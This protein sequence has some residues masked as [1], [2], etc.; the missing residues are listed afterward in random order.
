[1]AETWLGSANRVLTVSM[2]D[3]TQLPDQTE[4]AAVFD[5]VAAAD[6]R[7]YEDRVSE[8][9]LLA[10]LPRAVP[11]V[12]ETVLEPIDTVVWRLANGIRVYL[13]TTDFKND[14]ILFEALSP[15]GHSLV[16]DR[17]YIAAVTSIGVLEE[18]GLG[19]FSKNDLDSS[20]S[21]Q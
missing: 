8:E 7:P 15:G 5:R 9:P 10:D 20:F 6:I 13:K 2:P 11:V 4:L 1:M 12:E 16:D 21:C 18:A 3:E 19:P 14:E 17:D